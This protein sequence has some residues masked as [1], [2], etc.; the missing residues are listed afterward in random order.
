[1]AGLPVGPPPGGIRIFPRTRAGRPRPQAPLR[2]ALGFRAR[3]K[4]PARGSC[5][6]LGGVRG[7]MAPRGRKRKAEAAE[8]EAA[9]AEK[10]ERAAEPTVVIEH[11]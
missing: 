8:A 6:Q 10:Q 11:W 1:M 9:P 4:L 7:A 2:R 5:P 3:A